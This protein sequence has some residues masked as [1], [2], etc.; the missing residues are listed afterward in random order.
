MFPKT[1]SDCEKLLQALNDLAQKLPWMGIKASVVGEQIFVATM[2]ELPMEIIG[3]IIQRKLDNPV[4]LGPPTVLYL[5]TICK[6]AEAEGKYLRQT[7]GSG[8]YGHVKLGIRRG[9]PGTGNRFVNEITNGAIPDQFITPIEEGIREALEAGVLTG[10][11]IEDVV[12]TLSGGSYHEIDSNEMAYRIAAAMAVK[13]AARKA[14]PILL[15]PVMWI[16]A[17]VPEEY[18]GALLADLN[19]RRGRVEKVEGLPFAQV[20]HAV[21]PMAELLGYKNYFRAVTQGWGI[22]SIKFARYEA[23]SRGPD[24]DPDEGGV[25]ANKPSG[26]RPKI[27]YAYAEPETEFET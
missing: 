15:E 21:A 17:E 16:R 4:E 11:P 14:S 6:Q 2:N 13:E 1:A 26:P 27:G 19:R 18:L 25:T 9:E 24:S 23:A 10:H 5:E 8:N 22:L 3:P 20:I 12:V 7:G